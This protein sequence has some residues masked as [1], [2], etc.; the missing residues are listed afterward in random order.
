MCRQ[1]GEQSS[2]ISGQFSNLN[3]E[4]VACAKPARQSTFRSGHAALH[5]N[6]QS[7]C[8]PDGGQAGKGKQEA[9]SQ[10]MLPHLAHSSAA[11][12][13]HDTQLVAV[14]C[15]GHHGAEVV[16]SLLLGQVAFCHNPAGG[17]QGMIYHKH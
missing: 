13:V 12:P 8:D 7:S 4:R 5:L 3:N 17:R 14:R 1:A 11:L 15:H 10:A 6:A 2:R 9:A 16:S